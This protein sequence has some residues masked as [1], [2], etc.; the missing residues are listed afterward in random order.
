MKMAETVEKVPA[1]TRWAIATQG[2]TGAIV[3]AAKALLDE[4]GQERYNQVWGQ[5]WSQLGTASK[6]IA[7]A[8]GVTGDDAKSIAETGMF[9]TTVSMGPE[10]KVGTVEATSKKA[11]LRNTECPYWNRMKELGISD[12]ICS[13]ADPA[14]FNGFCKSLNPNVTVTLI[15]SM[16]Q[17]DPHCEWVYELKE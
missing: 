16:P 5:I 4:L 9:V 10:V 6:Q 15:K 11:V 2:L 12:D 8:L 13:V 14:Y 3:V 17:G 7:D 1:E